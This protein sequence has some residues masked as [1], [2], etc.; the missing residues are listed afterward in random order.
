LSCNYLT[1]KD[2]QSYSSFVATAFGLRLKEVRDRFNL[3]QEDLAKRMKL[4]RQANISAWERR[5]TPPEPETVLRLARSI[6][7]E[8]A[9]LLADVDTN[10]DRIRKGLPIET[11]AQRTSA[12]KIAVGESPPGRQSAVR[13][14][15]T[16]SK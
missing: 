7:C 2:L 11:R 4:K 10:Y 9:A 12:R 8:P 16:R 6:G 3:T 13:G 14:R 15:S 1:A 5:I